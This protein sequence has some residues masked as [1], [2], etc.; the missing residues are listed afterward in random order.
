M[1]NIDIDSIQQALTDI[2]QLVTDSDT[3]SEAHF[4][5]QSFQNANHSHTIA[6]IDG[7]HH[8]IKG[9]S[10]LFSTLRAGYLLYQNGKCI[11]NAIDPIK[12]EFIL[13][14]DVKHMGFRAKH[15]R[16]FYQVTGES[17]SGNLEFDK[18][19]ERIRTLLE[20][21]KVK[22]LIQTLN[23]DD[24]I[25]FDGS[26][27]SGEISTSHEFVRQLSE[28]A[29]SKGITLVGLSKDTSLSIETAPIPLVL[30][31]AAAKQRPNQNWFTTYQD[32]HFVRF[33]KQRD[34][35]F[36]VDAVLPP[37]LTLETVLSRIGAYCYDPATPGY[38]YP[39][40]KIH[41]SVRI[42]ELERNYCYDVFKKECQKLHLPKHT[43][44]QIFSIYHNQ[45]DKISL[46]R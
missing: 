32:T 18:V 43:L 11:K 41:D 4:S 26:L 45:L 36:R 3:Q 46:G 15:E 21:D 20:W 2:K 14:N 19:T 33:S 25:I 22:Y 29:Q 8:N 10:F 31:K 34:L 35:I 5:F 23:R 13:N 27:I 7:S 12:I 30:Q 38:P 37:D 6:A 39:M 9:M 40:Q 16:Y 17:S 44:Q 24:I 1:Y 42:S 28:M